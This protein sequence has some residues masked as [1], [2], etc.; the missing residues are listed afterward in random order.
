MKS[1]VDVAI[2]GAGAAGIGMGFILKA[3]GVKRF[4]ILEKDQIGASFRQWPKETRFITPSFYGNPY[5]YFD[6]NAVTPA[7]SPAISCDMEHPSGPRYADYLTMIA[8]KHQMPIIEQCSVEDVLPQAEGG[9]TLQTRQ[10]QGHAKLLI[11]AT[12]EYQ[13]PELRPFPG[14]GH[15]L[16]YANVETWKTFAC[17]DVCVIGGY[18]SGVDA[19]INMVHVGCKVRLLIRKAAMSEDSFDPSLTLSPYSR[20]R[21]KAAIKTGRLELVFSADITQVSRNNGWYRIQAKDGRIWLTETRPVLGTGFMGGGGARQIEKLFNWREKAVPQ[22]SLTDESTITPG[23]F[24]IGPQVRHDP[25]VFC[26]IYKFRQRL[27]VVATEIA[28]RLGLVM[29]LSND[30]YWM[31]FDETSGCCDYDC[32]C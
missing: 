32:K 2:V 10:G 11:W 30:P 29:P 14:A 31:T 3:I 6:L 24:L 8:T 25:Q 18:E 21:L 13:F 28:Q 7:S 5:G 16:H 17:K 12:G 1:T 19:A 4:V 22:L 15:C 27:A 20:E 9:F 23:L 26:F